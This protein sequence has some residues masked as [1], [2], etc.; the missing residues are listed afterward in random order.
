VRLLATSAA[1]LHPPAT[2]LPA[3]KLDGRVKPG[4][5]ATAGDAL[6]PPSAADLAGCGDAAAREPAPIAET[7][8]K[9]FIPEGFR[10]RIAL[11]HRSQRL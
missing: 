1:D 6:G 7:L 2:G 11:T 4:H 10:P 5:D 3:R 9:S 8:A